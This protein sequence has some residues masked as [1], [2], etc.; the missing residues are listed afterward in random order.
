MIYK[1]DIK[2]LKFLLLYLSIITNINYNYEH[3]N[4]LQ[5]ISNYLIGLSVYW[6]GIYFM[7]QVHSNYIKNIINLHKNYKK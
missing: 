5:I 6:N 1:S 4:M 2:N 3:F 7:E